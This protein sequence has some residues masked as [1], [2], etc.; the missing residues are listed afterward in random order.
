[1]GKQYKHLKERD[2]TFIKEQ[3]VFFMA[4]SSGK[5]VNLTPKGYDSL[6]VVDSTTLVFASYPGSGNRTYRDAVEGGEFTLMF[7][8]FEGAPLILK[9]YCKAEIIEKE[10]ERYSHYFSLFDIREGI[11]RNLF[12]FHIYAV[13]SSCGMAVPIMVYKEEREALREWAVDMDRRDALKAYN[14]KNFTPPNLHD[15]GS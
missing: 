5:E 1:M 6:R 7:T 2:I 8:A 9:A 11:V 12:V 13:E 3:K 15:L 4:S 14:Q 10:D